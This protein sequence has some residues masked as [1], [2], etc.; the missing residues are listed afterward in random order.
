VPCQIALCPRPRPS[1]WPRSSDQIA[2]FLGQGQADGLVHQTKLLFVLGQGLADALECPAELLFVLGQGLADALE[3]PAELLFVLGQGLADA[4]E[5]PAELLFVLGIANAEDSL[6][7]LLFVLGQGRFIFATVPVFIFIIIVFVNVVG[8][9]GDLLDAF[10]FFVNRA[11]DNIGPGAGGLGL[12]FIH[13]VPELTVGA[14]DF[15]ESDFQGL[16]GQ[17]HADALECRAE[18]LFVLG[19]GQADGLV[20]QTKLLFVLG[21]GLADALECVA[22]LF[23]LQS[24]QT[25][26]EHSF[27]CHHGCHCLHHHCFF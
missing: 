12:A 20:H 11:G 17:G 16:L 25:D 18:L 4:L 2:L 9:L 24:S 7:K 3:C 27:S 22:E 1:R 14:G 26:C 10:S 8:G 13:H 21:Q 15:R 5:C 19:Q 6:E 23:L